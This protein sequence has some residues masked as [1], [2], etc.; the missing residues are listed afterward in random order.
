[1]WRSYLTIALRLLVRNRVYAV[2]NIGGLALGLAGCLL[3]LSYVRYESSYET[4][5]GKTR[6][7]GDVWFGARRDVAA[8]QEDKQ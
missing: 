3:I 6:K 5:D 4:A 2:V 7:A 8:A 1:M